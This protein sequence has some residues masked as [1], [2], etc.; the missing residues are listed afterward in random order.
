MSVYIHILNEADLVRRGH[1]V[2][3]LVKNI[4]E[5]HNGKPDPIY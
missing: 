3:G 5:G 1:Q 4:N 2:L